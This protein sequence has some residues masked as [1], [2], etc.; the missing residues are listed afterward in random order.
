MKTAIILGDKRDLH[1]QHMLAACRQS[2]QETI[3]FDT[4]R[5]PSSAQIGWDPEKGQG[6][7]S[8]D[9]CELCFEDIGTVF[10]SSLNTCHTL[11]T[12]AQE[13]SQIALNDANSMLRTFLEESDIDWLNSWQVYQFHKVK[14]RQLYL[15]RETGATIPAT[16]IGNQAKPIVE[17]IRQYPKCIYKPVYGG[18]YT[19]SL[20]PDLVSETHLAQVLCLSPVTIQE[21]ISGTNVRTFVVGKNVFSAEIRS[22]YI[23]FRIEENAEH[24][25]IDTP[26]HIKQLALEI[27]QS[28]GMRW[29]AIDWRR[30]YH[31]EYYF[32]EANPSPMFVHFECVT[33]YPITDSLV[34]MIKQ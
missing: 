16:Y 33:G 4:A 23:D 25:A 30:N 34:E 13:Q 7:I 6:S 12:E 21:Y 2:G 31:G 20:T 29:T 27:S 5:Y 24:L 17:F 14:P 19:A 11:F 18:A 15:A 28:F 8:L 32:L 22:D 3:L 9:D 26:K 10:W 1:A